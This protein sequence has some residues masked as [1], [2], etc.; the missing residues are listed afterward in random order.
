MTPYM[1]DGQVTLLQGHVLDR[2]RELPAESVQC[3]VTSPPYWALRSYGTEPQVWGGDHPEHAHEWGCEMKRPGVGNNSAVRGQNE[4]STVFHGSPK[5]V[6]ERQKTESG[7]N[8]C[9]CGAWRGELGH[10]PTP[11]MFVAH[12]VEVFREVRRVLKSD[13]VLFVNLGDSMAGSGR[14]PQGYGGVGQHSK[15]QGFNEPVEYELRDDLT[16]EQIAY[17]EAELAKCNNL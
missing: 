9:P 4:V 5:Q 10:E 11:Q 17:V 1:D 13:G 8:T 3:C 12:L 16:P 7:G 2:L 6:H 15:R 14:G